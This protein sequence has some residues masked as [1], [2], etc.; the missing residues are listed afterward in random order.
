M[1]PWLLSVAALGLVL[2]AAPFARHR[3]Q[4]Q[5]SP[6]PAPIL[7]PQTMGSAAPEPEPKP[8]PAP[9]TTGRVPGL[10]LLHIGVDDTGATAPSADGAVA[11][12]TLDPDLQAAARA[13]L[14]AYHLPEAAIVAMDPETG[15]ILAY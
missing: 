6:L 12:L 1:R 8:A 13:I 4:A 10:D 9:P 2:A 14:A 15:A 7:L 5:A 3:G 11:K